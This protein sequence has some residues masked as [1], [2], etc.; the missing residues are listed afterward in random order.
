MHVTNYQIEKVLNVYSRKLGRGAD[1]ERQ[2]RLTLNLGEDRIS[3]STE[4]KRRAVLERVSA[5]ILEKLAQAGSLTRS[6]LPEASAG[7]SSAGLEPSSNTFVF[8]T[9]GEDQEKATT[10]ISL[11]DEQAFMQQLTRIDQ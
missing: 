7:R 5:D 3:L 4:G 11:S 1:A 8:N 2:E 6:H 9:I 10:T